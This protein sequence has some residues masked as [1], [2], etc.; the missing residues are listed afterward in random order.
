MSSERIFAIGDIHGCAE[1]LE[2]LL[3]ILPF[4]NT[5]TIVFLGDYIDRGPNSKKVIDL[6]LD[7]KKKTN[8]VCLK[9][10]HESMAIDFI[11]DPSSAQ[12]GLFIMNGGS[13]TL[14]SYTL[15]ADQFIIPDEHL[16]FYQSLELFYETDDYFFVHAGVPNIPLKKI[17]QEEHAME[18]LWLRSSFHNSSYKWGKIIVHGHTVV[19]DV[20]I[21]KNRINLD[22]GCVFKGKLSAIELPSQKIYQ[23]NARTEIPHVYLKEDPPSPRKATRFTGTVPVNIKG[24]HGDRNFQTLNYNEFGMLLQDLGDHSV[25]IEVGEIVS[26]TIGDS[27]FNQVEF[28][29]QIVRTQQKGD[30]LL[31]G[32]K[33][34]EP[35]LKN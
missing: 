30:T 10:N 1:E 3:A 31:Y 5:D 32:I 16:E 19:D 25:R 35:L 24:R 27:R 13:S 18:L 15:R 8:V 9:G 28:T 21:H 34:V 23:V 22:T 17:D 6:I 14:A 4:N 12:A 33:M 7:L 29:G 11:K 2:K 26:G 20:E